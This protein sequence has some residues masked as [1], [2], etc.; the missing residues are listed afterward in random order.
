MDTYDVV[1]L[2]AGSGGE[3]VATGLARAGLSVAVVERW[4]VGGDCPFTACMPSKAVLH[5]AAVSGDWEAARTHRDEVNDGLDDTAH[6]EGLAERGVD[7][8]RGVGAVLP[9]RRLRVT[10]DDDEPYDL[11]FDHFVLATGADVHV[12]AFPGLETVDAWTFE[13]LWTTDDLPPSV[14]VVGG[15]AVALEAATAL[16]QLGVD[17]VLLVRSTDLVADAPELE[18]VV[19]GALRAAGVDLRMATPVQ[20]VASGGDGVVVTTGNGDEVTAARLLLATGKRARVHGLGLEH[21]GVD[22]DELE[23]GLDGRVVGADKVWAVGDVTG[24][25]AFTHTANHLA[26]TVVHN[27]AQDDGREADIRH[28]PRGVFT[29][30]PHVLV[31]DLAP[32]GDHVRVTASYDDVAR[33]ATDR[34]GPGALVLTAAMDGEV[35]GVAGAGRGVDELA[36]AWTIMVALRLSVHDVAR[37]QQQFPTHGELTKLLAERAVDALT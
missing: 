17:V 7:L 36:S 34:T 30:P 14:V 31:G 9:E 4:L 25:P 33:P 3:N 1:V 37:V 28:T 19:R 24:F 5:E 12:P 35:L 16:G 29:D 13:E 26:A 22:P 2:G 23:V 10:P 6:A 15:G 8:H 21:L 32:D 11:R 18:D 27:L 20:H